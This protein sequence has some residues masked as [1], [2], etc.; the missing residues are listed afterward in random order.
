MIYKKKLRFF[1]KLIFL[2]PF[3]LILSLDEIVGSTQQDLDF[4]YVLWSCI[5][6][7]LEA[8]N[9]ASLIS[10]VKLIS[11]LL[12]FILLYGNYVTEYLAGIANV[13]FVRVKSR[14][15][16][17]KTKIM[18]LSV[19]AFV[20]ILLFIVLEVAICSCRVEKIVFDKTLI[21]TLSAIIGIVVPILIILIVVASGIAIKWG[22]SIGL[23]T[24]LL[25]TV[26][27]EVLAILKLRNPINIV[28]NP[29]CFNEMLLENP[30]LLAFKIIANCIYVEAAVRNL[31]LFIEHMD[32]WGKENS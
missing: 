19:Y 26:G 23:L 12:M 28:L 32:I 20:Y 9:V 6:G 22:S 5:F 24:A 13:F 17:S 7:N 18:E 31:V 10:S 4:S 14:K 16:W 30:R 1:I 27:L 21:V 25:L 15:K 29:M 8:G 3:L 2:I 11:S